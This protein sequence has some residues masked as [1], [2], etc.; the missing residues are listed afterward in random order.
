MITIDDERL[1]RAAIQADAEFVHS[2]FSQPRR[3]TESVSIL[4]LLPFLSLFCFEGRRALKTLGDRV[5]P[6]P[7]DAETMVEKSRH[8]VKLFMDTQREIE[9]QVAH[10]RQSL[11][12]AQC[13]A[14]LGN[15]WLPLARLFETDLAIWNIKGVPFSTTHSAYFLSGA[16]DSVIAQL[17]KGA[18]YFS[19]TA[20]AYGDEFSRRSTGNSGDCCGWLRLDA[21]LDRPKERK[22][23]RVYANCFNGPAS[24]DLNA[25]LIVHLALLR[26]A[27]VGVGCRHANGS[28]YTQFKIKYLALYQVLESLRSLRADGTQP[29]TAN[30]QHWTDAILNTVPTHITADSARRLRNLLVH[31][32][33]AHAGPP[34]GAGLLG[35]VLINAG[36]SSHWAT[37]LVSRLSDRALMHPG[38]RQVTALLA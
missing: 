18:T 12:P 29:L 13:G 36:V 11:V 25:T 26:L 35:E 14:F 4:S 5:V 33:P 34:A 23:V 2:L 32:I 10:F 30:S 20:K 8:T 3:G 17:Y 31:Y 24:P 19:D 21:D 6:L 37:I 1:A 28:C 9:G 22:S 38:C 15:T 16:P 7:P 27:Q